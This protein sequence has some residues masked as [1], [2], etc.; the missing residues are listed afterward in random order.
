M[1]E[2]L[3]PGPCRGRQAAAAV[4]LL[5]RREDLGQ[6]GQQP[7]LDVRRARAGCGSPRRSAARTIRPS[8]RR[9][10]TIPRPRCSRSSRTSRQL[11]DARSEDDEVHL[12]RHLLRHASSA[13]RLRRQRH[14]V[15]Q[16][17]RPGGSAG[18]TRRCS[19]R[20]ATPRRRRAGSPFVLDTNGNGKRDDYVEPNQPVDPPRTSASPAARHLRGHAEPGRRLDL[21]HRRRVRRAAACASRSATIR[22]DRAVRGLQRPD[23]GLRPARRRHRQQGRRVGVARQRPSRQLR[24]QQVQGPAQ[25]P[26]GDRRPLSGGLGVLSVSR[27]RASRASARTAPRRATTPGSTSTTR[28]GSAR[29]CRSRPATCND[30]FARAQGRQDGRCCACP[31][32][33]ASTPRGSTAASTIRTPAGRAAACGRQR[34]PHALAASKA[35]R[36]RSRMAV[37]FQMRPDP[38]AK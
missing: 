4:G 15:D 22:R 20:P 34:R 1:P 31:I 13:V 9:A 21:G 32:R 12:R 27:A 16:R 17:R 28:S 2:S 37:H 14:A 35:A 23:A 26:E 11:G 18:S 19:T 30:G 3:G 24:P 36:A 25:R 6:P 7:Q 33:W 5:G 10:P 38:L 8:A 29:T